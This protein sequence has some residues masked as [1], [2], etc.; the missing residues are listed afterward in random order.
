MHH[1]LYRLKP[2]FQCQDMHELISELGNVKLPPVRIL[3]T[4]AGR[5][6]GGALETLAPLGLKKV[7]PSD[8]IEERFDRPVVCQMEP[9]D[10]VR[11]RD[12]EDFD[13]QH[14]YYYPEEYESVFYPYAAVTDL[15]I[16]CHYWDPEVPGIFGESD[17]K[18]P[19]FNISVIADVSC[20]IKKPIASTLRA[21]TIEDPFYG[22]D[23]VTGT[24]KQIPLTAEKHNRHG[25]G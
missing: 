4:G 22:Y 15:F 25:S 21:S 19:D 3:I 12:G 20:D 10:Y 5:V 6:A 24:L 18:K 9:W 13:L 1:G 11:R 7:S 23:P 8:Y 2:A 14:F 17:Y 16:P